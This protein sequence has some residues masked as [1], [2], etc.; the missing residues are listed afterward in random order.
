MYCIPPN[1]TSQSGFLLSASCFHN[2]NLAITRYF[3]PTR[4]PVVLAPLKNVSAHSRPLP[5]SALSLN[6]AASTRSSPL[7]SSP[8]LA[9]AARRRWE[10]KK[11]LPEATR[12]FK[13]S[14][15]VARQRVA[16]AQARE[17]AA[18]AATEKLFLARSNG[19][20]GIV[21]EKNNDSVRSVKYS[22]RAIDI[23]RELGDTEREMR[24]LKHMLYSCIA[25]QWMEKAK[26]Y[27][28]RKRSMEEATGAKEDE[29]KLTESQI[30]TIE[31]VLSGRG[32]L[33]I[34]R[35]GN[36]RKVS[37]KRTPNAI[38]VALKVN[39]ARNKFLALLAKNRNGGAK[40]SK[41][42]KPSLGQSLSQGS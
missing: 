13:R 3:C 25:V 31:N 6:P 1:P 20:L 11:K 21:H 41:A 4:A 40:L 2:R 36:T 10:K 7:L 39:K 5:H 29:R 12:A 32:R 30:K 17:D 9:R 23:F 15:R 38:G 8:L 33:E 35:V 42:A 26:A 16:E 37:M 19:N 14:I 22:G 28:L 24:M 34:K 18:G 27:A